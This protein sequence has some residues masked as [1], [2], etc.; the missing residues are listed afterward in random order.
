MLSVWE[1]LSS[2]PNSPLSSSS[3]SSIPACDI[4]MFSSSENAK[5]KLSIFY[6]SN[7][8]VRLAVRRLTLSLHLPGQLLIKG[9]LWS[10]PWLVSLLLF[11]VTCRKQTDLV[12]KT[13]QT[14]RFVWDANNTHLPLPQLHLKYQLGLPQVP[15]SAHWHPGLQREKEISLWSTHFR[16]QWQGYY[17][18]SPQTQFKQSTQNLKMVQTNRFVCLQASVTVEGTIL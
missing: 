3:S 2:S 5:K 18:V 14:N 16:T 4:S 7:E 13:Y 12:S 9:H 6:A 8:S 10:S 1:A 15:C 11:S 17:I